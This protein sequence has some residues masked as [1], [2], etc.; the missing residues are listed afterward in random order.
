MTRC[1]GLQTSFLPHYI[2]SLNGA[3]EEEQNPKIIY[4]STESGMHVEW[5]NKHQNREI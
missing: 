4:N 1:F 5:A 2:R 3:A